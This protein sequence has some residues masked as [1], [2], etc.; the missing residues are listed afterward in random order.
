MFLDIKGVGA[1]F[2]FSNKYL[3]AYLTLCGN[4]LEF[5]A[6]KPRERHHILPRALFGETDFVVS[7]SHRE[8]FV[9]H[10][11][12][13]RALRAYYGDRHV[14]TVKMLSAVVIMSQGAV[15]NGPRYAL[16]RSDISRVMSERMTAFYEGGGR[17]VIRDSVTLL[18]SDPDFKA[19]MR[20]IRKL[21][22]APEEVRAKMSAS[23]QRFYEE[24]PEEREKVG[25]HFR[26]FYK[27]EENREAARDR[28]TTYRNDPT[29][30]AKINA[31]LGSDASRKANS[32][33]VK[34]KIANDPE[35]RA[36]VLAGLAKGRDSEESRKRQSALVKSQLQDPEFQAKRL[37]AL[38]A[39]QT[40]DALRGS[41]VELQH[42]DA[43]KKRRVFPD[44]PEY[45]DL[46]ASGWVLVKGT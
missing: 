2:G 12:L 42:P 39:R 6:P 17:E 9:A 26:E 4:R 27:D 25:Q 8:H 7:L 23:R 1:K 20:L 44:S 21:Q 30:R 46:V 29:V 24:N 37:E 43:P 34:A 33:R 36:K 10:R 45:S 38:R 16:L 41:R 22:F 40:A 11:M 18:W 19:K 31:K 28:L 13:W 3:R 5:P 32:E 15:C 35:Y 14:A